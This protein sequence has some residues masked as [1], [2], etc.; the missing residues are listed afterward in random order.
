MAQDKFFLGD[1]V[2]NLRTHEV[3]VVHGTA[4]PYI[5]V[6]INNHFRLYLPHELAKIDFDLKVQCD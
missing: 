3:G 4:G 1:K 5:G 6:I 2:M